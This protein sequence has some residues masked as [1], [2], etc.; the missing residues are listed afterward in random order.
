MKRCE[1]TQLCSHPSHTL[2]LLPQATRDSIMPK[3]YPSVLWAPFPCRNVS[4]S[5]CGSL[6][7]PG[8]EEIQVAAAARAGGVAGGAVRV[9]P[10]CPARQAAAVGL[11]AGPAP[12][13]PASHGHRAQ[14][15]PAPPP[16]G[17][18]AAETTAAPGAR[19]P[20]RSRELIPSQVRALLGRDWR[21][22]PFIS[23]WQ[24]FISAAFFIYVFE[25]V[26]CNLMFSNNDPGNDY[27][28]TSLWDLRC[29]SHDKLCSHPECMEEKDQATG[30]DNQHH[31]IGCTDWA[32]SCHRN[33]IALYAQDM[34]Q[35][36]RK[37]LQS[38]IPDWKTE[39]WSYTCGHTSGL[40]SLLSM[41]W[42]V[43]VGINTDLVNVY[44]LIF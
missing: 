34:S 43:H 18:W 4:A 30:D 22:N 32:H 5:L 35:K 27:F 40:D 6:L 10:G 1:R 42:T 20:G 26:C 37:E 14:P 16:A 44:V 17:V 38:Q 15:A 13:G 12:R 29:T 21:W 28:F 11:R 2:A 25:K 8:P 7:L 39:I 23:Q 31:G 9:P 33:Y 24:L 41:A 36:P 3:E 19:V